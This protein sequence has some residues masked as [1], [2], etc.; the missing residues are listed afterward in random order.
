MRFRDYV[1]PAAGEEIIVENAQGL[2]EPS[3]L[4]ARL[5]FCFFFDM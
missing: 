4:I 3:P 5:S 2:T 1:S